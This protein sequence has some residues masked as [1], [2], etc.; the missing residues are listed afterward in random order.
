MESRILAVLLVMLIA[1]VNCITITR[2]YILYNVGA[3][4]TDW[5][6][7]LDNLDITD[8]DATAFSFF[9]AVE[10]LSLKG[11]RIKTLPFNI[12]SSENIKLTARR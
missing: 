9:T 6:L 2:D 11:N 4:R 7:Y 1:N 5:A 10:V 3:K 12:F 8:I